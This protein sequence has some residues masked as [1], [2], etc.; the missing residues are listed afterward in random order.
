VAV[1]ALVPT[2]KPGERISQAWWWAALLPFVA[3]AA[4]FLLRPAPL[5]A[6]R[7][8]IGPALTAVY[9]SGSVEASVMLPVAPRVGGRLV[10]L[11]SD[12]N[13]EV[14]KGQVLGRLE[15]VDVISN[16][17]QLQANADFALTDLERDT[18]LWAQKAIAGQVY[19]RAL[20]T[21]KAA[22]A[23]VRQARA[24]AGYMTLRAPDNCLVIQRDGEIGQYIAANTP[25]FWLSCHARLRISAL[26][27]EEDVVMVRPG[28]QVVIRA[29]AFPGRIFRAQV[30]EV[31]P[32][33]DPIGRSYR[34]RILLP[35]DTPLRIGMTTESNILIRRNDRALLL[36]AQAV[37]DGKIWKI[38]NG[39]ARK[40]PVTIGAKA[41]DLVE[42]RSGLSAGDLVLRDG[43]ARPT[44]RP[45]L[46]LMP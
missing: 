9:G 35:L 20:A 46:R 33:G 2:H 31:T 32:K 14:R 19:D 38:E 25:I 37:A 11:A 7:P 6:V 41:N 24:Q 21:W 42:I 5:D 17:A 12:E 36:P 1:T 15:D 34:V 18:R 23:A 3:A 29:D 4:W 22:D 44:D 8:R 13:V 28:Q 26:V 10:S 40:V 45:R 43:Q 27:D 16:I 30:T 39:K